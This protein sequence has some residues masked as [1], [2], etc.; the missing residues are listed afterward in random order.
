MKKNTFIVLAT[1]A[2][3]CCSRLPEEGTSPS[4]AN[5]DASTKVVKLSDEF[6]QRSFLVK[7]NAVPSE[8]TLKDLTT[9][10]VVRIEKLFNSV[11]GKEDLE[12]QFGLDRWYEVFVD[13]A[14]DIDSSIKS[15]AQ[16]GEVALVEYNS[17]AKKASDCVVYPYDGD[18]VATK[19]AAVDEG[20]QFND[21]ALVDQWHYYNQGNASV[22]K[23]VVKGADINV[24]DVWRNLTCG[25]PDIIVAVV[26]E[27]VKYTHQDLADN[28]WVNTK[29][30][31]GNG[32]DDDKNGYIDDVYGYNFVDNGAIS[33]TKSGDTGHGTHCA[34]TIAAVNNNGKGV[35]GVAGGTG[36]GDGCRIM[37]CQIF[38]GNGGGTV[39]VTVKAIKYAADNGA[40]IISCSFGYSTAFASD[41]AYIKS[42]GSAEID[43][44]HYFEA[45]KNN[46]VLDGNVAIF[47]A[48]NDAHPY[49]HYPGAFY[50]II[51]V[52]A[53][54]PDYLPTYYT[55]YGPGC[56]VVAPGGE[57][58]HTTT[59]FKSMV[60]STVPSELAERGW[61]TGMAASSTGHD[62]GYM[63]GTSMACPHVSGITALALSYAKKLGKHF[64]RDKFK[65]MIIT[66]ANDLDSRLSGTKTYAYGQSPLNLSQFY[67]QL[68]T[69][70]IDTWI[71]MMQVEGIPCLI[72][73]TG[74]N[75]WLD[76]SP[77]FG[78]SSTSL[79][80]LELEVSDEDA[81]A[82]GLKQ[83]P[84]IQYGR[85]Y[86]YPTKI[87]SGK[88]TIKAVGGGTSI[89]GGSNPP[90]GMEVSQE[91]SII[92]R[93]FKSQNGGWL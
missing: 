6:S 86:V 58:Y 59:S 43:A 30:I 26:D 81:A 14:C 83:D 39:S 68:G 67:H 27:G 41:D 28:M 13:E 88:V 8:Q 17:I 64:S 5:L 29:E 48:G 19:A 76:I 25:D 21:P 91:I 89:G 4:P 62:Y 15:V 42:Q 92:T 61:G 38:S 75:Q 65:E 53:F 82:L 57:A 45:S 40:S 7:F 63:Q 47:A 24:K 37:S 84:Y 78:T 66:S 54:A 32:I 2:L 56:N 80:Y 34:G 51:S 52:T 12:R 10:G 77:Y 3:A 55:N 70:S 33:W 22:S 50:D 87:G 9:V 71:L 36:N 69:G 18:E 72:A 23:T 79:T 74:R 44:I 31:P 11:E 73:E 60:L 85:L 49:A 1:L 20:L 16:S 35:C 46:T 90:G 93:P